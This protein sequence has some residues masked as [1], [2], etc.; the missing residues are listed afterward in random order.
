[1]LAGTPAQVVA[2]KT[3]IATIPGGSIYALQQALN[4]KVYISHLN[5]GLDV[6]NNPNALGLACNFTAGALAVT[7]TKLGIPN[8]VESFFDTSLSASGSAPLANA[9]AD[10]T[11]CQGATVTLQ[12]SGG[13]TY[14]WNT[15]QTSAAIVV[16]P[17]TGTTYTVAVSSA[18]GSSADSVK[19]VVLSCST[20]PT[21]TASGNVICPG[22]CATISSAI[23]GG[24]APYAYSWNPGGQTDAV[25]VVCPTSVAT[26]TVLVTDA[27]NNTG[28]DTATV[29]VYPA[30]VPVITGVTSIC[31]G[32][33]TTLTASGG[34]NYS[35]NT[36]ATGTAITVSPTSATSY[37]LTATHANGCSS[38]SVVTVTISSP[39]IVSVSAA[40]VCAG[41]TAVLTASGGGNYSW[42]N[43]ANTSSI[44]VAPGS[45]ASYSVIVSVG[46][47]S[48][49]AVTQVIVNPIPL[50]LSYGS[51]GITMGQ[52]T[53]L[54]ASGGGNYL[55]STGDTGANIT[56][57]PTATTVYCITV[58]NTFGCS[59]SSCLSVYVSAPEIKCGNVYLPNAFSPNGDGENDVFKINTETEKCLKYLKLILYNRWGE[60]VFSSE[61]SPAS[62]GKMPEWDG[63]YS[64]ATHPNDWNPEGTAVFTYYLKATLVSGEEIQ[65]KGN[66][67]LLR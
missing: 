54:A 63:T 48:S 58:T 3:Y 29:S 28:I 44:S 37:T 38:S 40:T 12:A 42:S 25:I 50:A 41:Q 60:I 26:Y 33:A 6:I 19:V 2:S 13:G 67:S 5:Q 10:V 4:G 18:C 61:N 46:N 23:L 9:G 8:F 21:V 55:W 36:G 32:S 65:K 62:D 22:S 11:I 39:P 30:L 45:T 15:G 31:T 52:S 1:M 34:I 56:V 16:T 14:S 64:N 57:F 59:D 27:N 51:T 17:A 49:S 20:S 35:W 7:G 24:T 53:T 43:G 47:C 66:V